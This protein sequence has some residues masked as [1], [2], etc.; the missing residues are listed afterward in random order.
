MT[1]DPNL[2]APWSLHFHKDGTEDIGT[3]QDANGDTL[4]ES[5]PFWLPEGDDPTPPTLYA[6][7]LMAVAP[8]LLAAAQATLTAFELILEV[9]NPAS[10]S[11]AEFDADPLARLRAVIIEA[12]TFEATG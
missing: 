12:E 2:N 3:I 9:D 7:R 4:V 5:R 6:L 8:K 11:L 1:Q 10:L